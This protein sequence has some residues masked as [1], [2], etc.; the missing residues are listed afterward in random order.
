MLP[1]NIISQKAEKFEAV[2]HTNSANLMDYMTRIARGITNVEKQMDQAA[3][4]PAVP[5][6]QNA[7]ASAAAASAAASATTPVA[8]PAAPSQDSEISGLAKNFNQTT[9]E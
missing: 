3:N 1:E 2:A 9:I 5:S 8:P 4:V 7:S 6:Q